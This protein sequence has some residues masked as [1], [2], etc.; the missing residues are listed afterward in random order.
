MTFRPAVDGDRE[1]WQALLGRVPSGDFLH[2]WGWAAVAAFDG[3][4]QR[5]FVVEDD[6]RCRRAGAA[7]V[8]P[9]GLGRTFWYVPTAR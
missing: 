5:R 7:Q 1:A 4:P 6:G 8:R 2:D 9:I 3:Q